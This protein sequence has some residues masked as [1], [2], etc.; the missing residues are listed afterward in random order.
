MVDKINIVANVRQPQY[1]SQWKVTSIIWKMEEDLNY[2]EN[3]RQP[4]LFG[5][6]KTTSIFNKPLEEDGDKRYGFYLS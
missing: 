1:F 3:G 6:W 2:L 4:Q 5:K